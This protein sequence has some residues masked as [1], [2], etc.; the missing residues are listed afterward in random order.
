MNYINY[1]LKNFNQI[2]SQQTDKKPNRFVLYCKDES[3]GFMPIDLEFEKEQDGYYTIVSAM[4][5]KAKIKGTLLFDGSA[6]PSITTTSDTLLAKTGDKGGAGNNANTHGK[7]N[8][9]SSTSNISQE[10]K[11]SKGTVKKKRTERAGTESNETV[12]EGNGGEVSSEHTQGTETIQSEPVV[13]DEKP[14]EEKK[15]RIFSTQEEAE[16]ELEKALG[17]RPVKKKAEEKPAKAKDESKDNKPKDIDPKKFAGVDISEEAEAQLVAALKQALE[18]SRNRLNSLP[19][20]DPD[21]LAPAFKLGRL[22]VAR[23]A[24]GFTE[25]AK[26]MIDTLGDDIR[27]WLHPVWSMLESADGKVD[28]SQIIPIFNYVGSV[29]EKNPKASFEDIRN[30]FAEKYCE[31]NAK[32]FEPLLKLGFIGADNVIINPKEGGNSELYDSTNKPAERNSAGNNQD[33]V[34]AVHEDGESRTGRGQSV[35]SSG[36]EVRSQRSGSVHGRSTDTSGKTGNSR[37]QSE[38]TKQSARNDSTGAEHLSRS[39]RDSFDRP[40]VDDGRSAESIKSAENRPV[41]ES[42]K[43]GAIN[44]AKVDKKN[45]KTGS[46]K[47]IEASMPFLMKGQVDDVVKADNRLFSTDKNGKP[48]KGMMFTNGTGTGKTFTGLGVI[49]RFVQRGK[50]NILIIA[51]Q[52]K[53]QNDWINAGKGFF[54]LD[55]SKL[56]STKDKGEGIVIT[57]YQNVGENNALLERDWD[58]IVTDESHKLM[59]GEQANNTNALNQVCAMTYHNKGFNDYYEAK[60]Y[61]NVMLERSLNSR[62][63]A[64]D[65]TSSDR[66]ELADLH[67]KNERIRYKLKAEYEAMQA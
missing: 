21:I 50:K 18:K 30:E 63:G 45:F 1:I 41:N 19:V 58:L 47:Q 15:H 6:N 44:G 20:F 59:Q 64:S 57:S 36:K 12:A 28:E 8:V 4:P 25:F 35:Q 51:P 55:I 67:V 40:P 56:K 42:S 29:M 38:E 32:D 9:P 31:D 3:K 53:T 24:K 60:N 5:H 62:A 7:N 46:K 27:G 10:Q 37:V 11:P 16:K 49:K 23:G 65:F 22:Y 14:K 39:T 34:G 13:K 33:A 2:Y 66:Q 48:Y 43:R 54:G 61:D 17:I 52:D 26:T